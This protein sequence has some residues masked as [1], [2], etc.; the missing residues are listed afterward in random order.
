MHVRHC[1][2]RAR[3]RLPAPTHLM[4]CNGDL[5]RC[6]CGHR[7]P[8]G[9]LLLRQAVTQPRQVGLQER[10]CARMAAAAAAAA[11]S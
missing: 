1:R 7:V 11:P 8:R 10:V 2:A 3:V 6:L 5:Q 4:L 9:R